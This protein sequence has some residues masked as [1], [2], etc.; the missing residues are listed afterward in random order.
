[1]AVY[2]TRCPS[3]QQAY[4]LNDTQLSAKDGLVR[5]GFCQNVFNAKEHLYRSKDV[6][7][8]TAVI[9]AEREAE[10]ERKGVASMAALSAQLQGFDAVDEDDKPSGLVGIRTEPRL[11]PVRQDVINGSNNSI[12]IIQHEPQ[13]A[14][15]TV[16]DDEEEDEEELPTK[17][18]TSKRGLW[19]VIA[20]IAAL[21]IGLQ[22]SLS[23]RGAII[24]KLPQSEAMFSTLCQYFVCQPIT[25]T[26]V[27]PAEEPKNVVLASQS[28]QRVGG[29]EYVIVANL[30]NEKAVEEAF[31]EMTIVLKGEKGDILTRRILKPTDYLNDATQKLKPNET[32]QVAFTFKIS[33]GVPNELS[34]ELGR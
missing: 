10:M 27:A 26:S 28:L 4:R 17:K 20:F 34:I 23:F 30:H 11:G 3:C 22:L 16:E 12:E 6:P 9:R 8:E 24:E 33:E 18:S 1:M 32:R 15:V 7:T 21:L 29:D 19:I 25:N 14:N 5:C 31:P 13:R 2:I